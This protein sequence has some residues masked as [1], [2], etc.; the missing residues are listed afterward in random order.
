MKKIL[1]ALL[2]LT[3]LPT[4]ANYSCT[5][6][7]YKDGIIPGTRYLAAVPTK[8]KLQKNQDKLELRNLELHTRDGVIPWYW[9]LD[10]NLS[11][12]NN[13]CSLEGVISEKSVAIIGKRPTHEVNIKGQSSGTFSPTSGV[14]VK[15]SCK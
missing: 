11:C 2:A 1:F 6:S 5:V 4:F 9:D 14:Y 10:A 8:F 7:T 12:E 3:S 15:I 13:E